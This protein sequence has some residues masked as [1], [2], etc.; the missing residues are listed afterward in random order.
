MKASEIK[1]KARERRGPLLDEM[2]RLQGSGLS[3]QNCSGPCCTYIGNSMKVTPSETFDLYSHLKETDQWH[4]D[5]KQRLE[6]TVERF[7]LGS[8]FS[9]GRRSFIRKT[10][11]C[12]FYKD[13]SL[14]CSIAKEF[15]P[16]GCLGF[17]AGRANEDSGSRIILILW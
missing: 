2:D 6:K 17:N 5:L 10:Y 7:R 9:D 11:T 14:G 13:R 16:F 3:C 12:P 15:K 8:D 4:L 1:V